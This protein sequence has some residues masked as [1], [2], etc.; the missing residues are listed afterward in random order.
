MLLILFIICT[1]PLRSGRIW[2]KVID[3]L[4]NTLPFLY[5]FTLYTA[6][7]QDWT[8]NTR[9]PVNN[10]KQSLQSGFCLLVLDL[11]TRLFA[12]LFEL[13][14]LGKVW[15]HMLSSSSYQ[16]IIGQT[17]FFL[18]LVTQPVKEKENSEFKSAVLYLKINFVSYPTSGR[19]VW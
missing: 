17:R 12:F 11:W 16:Q 13:M 15:I 8:H 2:H 1:Q 3:P 19:R 4:C 10:K 9:E 6:Y 5:W 18:A 7:Y 14:P